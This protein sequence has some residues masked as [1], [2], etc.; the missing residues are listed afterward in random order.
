MCDAC[1]RTGRPSLR[2][3]LPLHPRVSLQEIEKWSVDFIGPIQ[4]PGK[5][6]GA[7]YIITVTEYLT[8]WVEAQSVKDCTG[9]TIAKLLFEYVLYRFG[10]LKV[11]MSD[12]GT[13]FLNAM[14]SS[15]A[16]E[17]QVYHQK[18]TPYHLQENKL[19]KPLTIFWRM[20]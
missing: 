4:T 7:C 11:L 10:C 3:E 18:C 9:D 2:Y 17:F 14:I 20:C 1:Q 8:R 13:H 19:L 6:M 16:E 12:R 15:L 5:K